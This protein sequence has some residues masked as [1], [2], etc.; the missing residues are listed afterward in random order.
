MLRAMCPLAA[1]VLLVAMPLSAR[2]ETIVGLVENNNL[3]IFDSAR[4][5]AILSALPIT[6]TGGDT[7]LGIDFRPATGQLYG[8]GHL[9][10]PGVRLYI[11]DPVT[12]AATLVRELAA[13]P[14]D[15]YAD[16]VG[17]DFG[18]RLQPS[19]RS[20]PRRHGHGPELT[21]QPGYGGGFHGR[22]AGLR[23]G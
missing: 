6:N 7:L 18:R 13:D 17:T 11:I 19:P 12:G 21:R 4:P 23:R 10:A 3:V 14:T 8:F 9:G 20:H 5:S 22:A 16:V 1:L 2:A 15:P